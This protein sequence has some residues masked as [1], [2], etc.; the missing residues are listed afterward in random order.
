M[1][2]KRCCGCGFQC[3]YADAEKFFSRCLSRKDGLQTRCMQCAKEY[4]KTHREEI[5]LQRQ[6]YR[7]THREELRDKSK[8][9]YATHIEKR[10]K[11]Q[12]IYRENHRS[13]KQAYDIVYYASQR[14]AIIIRRRLYYASHR[15]EIL[16]RGIRYRNTRKLYNA[17]LRG[18]ELSRIRAKNRRD[19]KRSLGNTITKAE[20][21]AVLK[22]HTNKKG[23]IICAW[24]GKPVGD[25]WHYDHWIP[26]D[27]GGRHEVGNLRVMH[28]HTGGKCNLHKGSR[29]PFEFGKL[30]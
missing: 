16:S 13:E 19:L 25:K 24:C 6:I 18:K 30:I 23:Q 15:E 21:E 9:D 7:E 26:L 5:Q 10:R 11:S 29:M 14:Q 22:A 12:A 8:R 28:G 3:S 1:N 27:K 20:Y 17:S 4:R 2:I